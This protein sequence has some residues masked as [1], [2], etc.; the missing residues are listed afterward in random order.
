MP[1]KS[2]YA[3]QAFTGRFLAIQST[4]FIYLP[5]NEVE[6]ALKMAFPK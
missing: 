5:I 2:F 3:K 1:P 6:A 4:G